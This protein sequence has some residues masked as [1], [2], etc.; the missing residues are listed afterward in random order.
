M[1][2]RSIPAEKLC[3]T[4]EVKE[5]LTL[6]KPVVAL[7]STIITHGM[8][9]P[10]NAQT[11]IAV[12]NT[13]RENGATPATIAVL[14]GH[15]NIGLS[16]G[17]IEQL[18]SST[19]NS[20]KISRRDFPWVLSQGLS[21]GTTV[22]GTMI[23]AY[24]A[25]IPIFATGGIGGVHRGVEE[26]MDISADLRELG[27]TPVAVVAAGVKSILDISRT[28]EFLET[29][30]VCVVTYGQSRDFPAFF[31]PKSGCQ[32]PY[33]I[34]QPEDAA[35]MI[36]AIQL[37]KLAS[38]MLIAVP[39]PEKFAVS[40]EAI[41]TAIRDAVKK[42]KE[43]GISGN[44]VTP[45][46]LQQVNQLTQ[47]ASLLA[48][49]LYIELVKNNAKVA[50]E[51]AV[52]LAC[53]RETA[54]N[55][56]IPPLPH[57]STNTHK[58]V[59]KDAVSLS[60]GAAK[61]VVVGGAVLDFC[62]KVEENEI[63]M[64]GAT[65]PGK[66][67]QSFGGVGYNIANC[68]SRLGSKPLFV[69]AIGNDIHA[70]SLLSYSTHMDMSGVIQLKGYSTPTYCPV[71]TQSGQLLFGIGD[72]EIHSQFTPDM[73][74]KFQDAIA[75]APLV[76]L[77]G[78]FS[79]TLIEQVCQLCENEGTPVWFDPTDVHKAT[80]LFQTHA[81]KKLTYISPNFSEAC[82]I[83]SALTGKTP[84]LPADLS[85]DAVV[86]TAAQFCRDLLQHIPVIIITLGRY[87]LLLAERHASFQSLKLYP[88]SPPDSL[89]EVLSESGAGDCLNGTMI[90]FIIQG[91][92]LDFCVKAGL[93][94]AQ[95]SLRSYDAVPISINEANFTHEKIQ[96]WA[97]FQ[98]VDI[99]L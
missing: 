74:K 22:S 73:L 63:K 34:N 23:A 72:M 47:G 32:A 79:A 33:N 83:W 67:Y 17:Q 93:M 77:D 21:G 89:T 82:H 66:L 55:C 57:K 94:A 6:G 96:Q 61:P 68:M 18:A 88:P 19:A 37:M 41:E 84:E 50:S 27:R 76:C 16:E 46:I 65:Y 99:V 38:G 87:G 69:S 8:P 43:A 25:G 30:G 56:S 49:I 15:I 53:K 45:F 86:K 70:S 95:H 35:N 90:H 20:V 59:T 58:V 7:E 92:G 12:E 80:K 91:Y 44:N 40:G 13:V 62:A 71:L 2:A 75:S 24:M 64:S 5:A 60:P 9:Y 11:A 26:T 81:W 29:E 78:N 54:L 52:A 14:A 31:S 28:L 98:A 39:L 10:D 85:E 48:N 1:P 3:F 4:E 36:A 42:A 97:H 51:I